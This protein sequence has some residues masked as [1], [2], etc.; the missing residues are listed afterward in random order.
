MVLVEGTTQRVLRLQ[1][2]ALYNCRMKQIVATARTVSLDNSLRKV[3]TH[4]IA[5]LAQSAL[6]GI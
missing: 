3:L 1:D 5:Q 6:F 4:S 2:C